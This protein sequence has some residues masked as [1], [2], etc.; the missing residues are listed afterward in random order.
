MTQETLSNRQT[1]R[2]GWRAWGQTAA[3]A[4][5]GGR[6]WQKKK[7]KKMKLTDLIKNQILLSVTRAA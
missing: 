2:V 1:N 4:G 5:G 7:N 6:E 3:A